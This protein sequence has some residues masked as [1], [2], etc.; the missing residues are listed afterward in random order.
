MASSNNGY[1]APPRKTDDITYVNWKKEV[2]IWSFQTSIEQ[3]K[4]G[5]ALFLSLEGK[6]RQTVL[7]EV[8][9]SDI[10]SYYKIIINKIIIIYQMSNNIS[11]FTFC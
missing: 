10:N 9:V 5:S 2:A 7:A 11:I 3:V 4:Q 8:P 1:K 6:P